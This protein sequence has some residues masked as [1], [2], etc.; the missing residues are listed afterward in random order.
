MGRVEGV[1]EGDDDGENPGEEGQDLVSGDGSR[2]VLFPL[3]EGV[4]CN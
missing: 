3:A 4:V 2:A 1:V